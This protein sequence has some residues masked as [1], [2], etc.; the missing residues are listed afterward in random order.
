MRRPDLVLH[1]LRQSESD[2]EFIEYRSVTAEVAKDFYELI[3]RY[4]DE[5]REIIG[6]YLSFREQLAV[7]LASFAYELGV[8]DAKAGKEK[9]GILE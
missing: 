3:N 8:R 2:R 4:P 1:I 5:E 7:S 9:A 6:E